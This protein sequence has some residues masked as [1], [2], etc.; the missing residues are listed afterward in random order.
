[1]GYEE[2]LVKAIDS[3]PECGSSNITG[4]FYNIGG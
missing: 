3:K 2:A 1:M 4:E